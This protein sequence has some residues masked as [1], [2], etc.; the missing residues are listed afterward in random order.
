M[1]ALKMSGIHVY[2][3]REVEEVFAHEEHAVWAG[4]EREERGDED[5]EAE[6]Q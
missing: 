4:C 3:L 5:D 1:V 2:F 6:D